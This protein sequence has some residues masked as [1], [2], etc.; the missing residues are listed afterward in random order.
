MSPT[1]GK[2]FKVV[3]GKLVR[4]KRKKDASTI[5]RER[6]SKKSRAVSPATARTMNSIGKAK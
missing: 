3:D 4:T 1:L 6:K 5:I 2:G